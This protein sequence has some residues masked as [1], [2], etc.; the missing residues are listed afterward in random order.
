MRETKKSLKAYFIVFSVIGFLTS[1]V[2]IINLT[3]TMSKISEAIYMALAAGFI[4][5]GLKLDQYLRNSPQ[6]LKIF[7]I[8]A[9]VIQQ[10][11]RLLVGGIDLIFMIL[12]AL[13]AWY[14]VHNIN[15]LSAQDKNE[16]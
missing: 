13:V 1:V 12:S 4:Y 9:A 8:A 15:K 10:V 16:K 3:G 2:G 5:Y 14:L 7:V 11:A 6:T